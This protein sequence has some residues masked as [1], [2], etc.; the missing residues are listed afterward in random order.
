ML[1]LLHGHHLT[2]ESLSNVSNL[3]H[4][5]PCFL[6]CVACCFILPVPSASLSKMDFYST[7]VLSLFIFLAFSFFFYSFLSL[8]RYYRDSCRQRGTAARWDQL[9]LRQVISGS[10]WVQLDELGSDGEP[11][12]RQINA[13]TN[14]KMGLVIDCGL[15]SFSSLLAFTLFQFWVPA[16]T[17]FLMHSLC[18]MTGIFWG[19]FCLCALNWF[20]LFYFFNWTCYCGK[21]NEQ[22]LLSIAT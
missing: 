1:S 16:S 10:E 4:P 15:F 20:S 3:K 18:T 17:F 14:Y 12:A 7:L 19:V 22:T 11:S 6:P 9:G 21:V 2:S 5:L 13:D 8:P